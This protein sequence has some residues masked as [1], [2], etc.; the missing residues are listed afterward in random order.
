M[1]DSGIGMSPHDVAR[2]GEEFFRVKSART[3]TITGS[4]LGMALMKKI[5]ESYQGG[6]EVE[7]TLDVGSTFRVL[8]PLKP[9]VEVVQ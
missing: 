1:Q 3:R 7:S 8:L 6:F 9:S 2:L 4:G 5:V